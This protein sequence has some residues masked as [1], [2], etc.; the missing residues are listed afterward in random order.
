MDVHDEPYYFIRSRTKAHGGR[1]YD[2][3]PKES[4]A[5]ARIVRQVFEHQ[6]AVYERP[7][8]GADP[9]DTHDLAWFFYNECYRKVSLVRGVNGRDVNENEFVEEVCFRAP[10]SRRNAV[11]YLL[12]DVGVGKTALINRLITMQGRDWVT[13]RKR[14]FVRVDCES[15]QLS[16]LPTIEKLV[17]AIADKMVR[18]LTAHPALRDPVPEFIKAWYDLRTHTVP[19]S[20]VSVPADEA[21]RERYRIQVAALAAIVTFVRQH[22]GRHLL[23][24]IDNLDVVCHWSD[25]ELFTKPEDTGETLALAGTC[26]LA[27][28]FFHDYSLLGSLGAYILFVMRADTYEV[29]SHTGRTSLMPRETNGLSWFSIKRP[30]WNSVLEAR[31][32]LLGYASSRVEPKGTRDEFEDT[33]ARIRKH[34]ESAQ[35]EQPKLVEHLQGLTNYGLREVMNFFARYCWIPESGGG[36]EIASRLMEQ[37]HVGLITYF[38][39]DRC[40][41]SQCECKFPNIYLTVRQPRTATDQSYH[42]PH[43]YWLKRLILEYIWCKRGQQVYPGQVISVFSEGRGAYSEALVRE[44]LGSLADGNVS[45]ILRVDRHVLE[46]H[47]VIHNV[48]LT[49]RGQHCMETVFDSFAYLQVIVD[50]WLFPLPKL[51]EGG[52]CAGD[53]IFGYMDDYGYIAEASQYGM[54]LTNMIRIKARQVLY[55][56]EVLG[57]ALD[58]EREIY[59][60]VFQRLERAGIKLDVCGRI[61]DHVRSELA[62]IERRRQRP[63]GFEAIEEEVRK[64]SSEVRK[65]VM[66][67]FIEA[68]KERTLA[69]ASQAFSITNNRG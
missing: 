15:A 21:T 48:R 28:Q 41:F 66:A 27:K 1:I 69:A 32:K 33:T 50:E 37:Y 26:E 29:M 63:Y 36:E 16:P 42:H 43:S 22:H 25:R 10:D 4:T 46:E 45:N 65:Y 38:L 31:S 62:A 2:S 12:G 35:V 59:K 56:L 44:C 58:A 8:N 47:M 68:E 7:G 14:W 57:A 40:R 5:F 67:G 55:L 34:L 53:R 19:Q 64:T 61:R 23:L 54:R 49:D 24:I 9:Q 39:N 13:N 52:Q 17:N 30:N 6:P 20:E 3:L 51:N 60:I 18:V 11:S